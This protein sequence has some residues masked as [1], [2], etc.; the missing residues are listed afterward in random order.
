MPA[1]L[2]AF[3]VVS[4]AT[5]PGARKLPAVDLIQLTDLIQLIGR[6]GS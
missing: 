3:E 6:R 1:A 5:R 2:L 4:T